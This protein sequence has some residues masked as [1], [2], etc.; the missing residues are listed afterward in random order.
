MCET[1][2]TG[3]ELVGERAVVN[4]KAKQRKSGSGAF[5]RAVTPITVD[6]GGGDSE[7]DDDD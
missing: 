7:V 6:E 3:K 1:E 5:A 4:M 2:W